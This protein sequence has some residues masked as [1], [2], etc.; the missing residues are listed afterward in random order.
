VGCIEPV[1]IGIGFV[2]KDDEDVQLIEEGQQ[3]EV[4]IIFCESS[5]NNEVTS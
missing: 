2:I 1:F 5:V 4:N 3:I